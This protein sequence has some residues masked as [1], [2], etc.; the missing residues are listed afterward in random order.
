MNDRLSRRRRA[1]KRARPMLLIAIIVLFLSGCTGLP[2]AKDDATPVRPVTDGASVAGDPK[3]ATATSAVKDKAATPLTGLPTATAR[4]ADPVVTIALGDTITVNG[5]GA[6]V[7]GSAV[8][9]TAGG[10]YSISGKLRNGQIVVDAKDG[11]AVRLVLNGVDI[12]CASSAPI[13]VK[14]AK[15][16]IIALADGTTNHVTDENTGRVGGPQANEP[17]AAIFSKGNLSFEGNGSLTVDAN[18]RNAI[19]SKDDLSITGGDFTVNAVNDGIE[20]RD[21]I[22]IKNG[23]I[24]V[25]A[26]ADGMRSNNDVDPGKGSITI[27]GG[28]VNVTAGED[29]IQAETSVAISGGTIA[30]SS[31]G[32]SANS[33]HKIGSGGNA[34]EN[35]ATASASSVSAKGIK[36]GLNVTIQGGAITVDSSDDA[37]NSNDTL[38]IHDGNLVL[39]SGDDGIHS[40]ITLI[41]DGGDIRVTRSYEAIEGAVIVV[42]G[43]NVHLAASDDGVNAADHRDHASANGRPGR[44]SSGHSVDTHLSVTGGY[45]VVDATGDG[46]D[47]NGWARMTG[48]T[49]IVNGPVVS[50]NGALDYNREFTMAGGTLVAVGSFG[51]AQAPDATS[52]QNSL[53]VSLASPQPA[54]TLVHIEAEDGTGILTF[55]PIRPYQSVVYS[56]SSLKKGSTY[57]VY[58]GG[59]STGSVVDGVYSGGSYTPGVRTARPRI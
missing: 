41:I 31:G 53:V 47:I 2:I 43:G 44:G 11:K 5:P 13:Y 21:H 51:M 15:S 27:E 28:T 54:G 55:A 17:D 45:V 58:I 50:D 26:K 10:T 8:R 1:P 12:T 37:I 19:T 33:R 20:G 24:T 9:I 49:V 29:G 7:D 40:D 57:N 22:A 42:N 48:G 30:V 35:P 36:A 46:L 32:G 23:S 59:R 39:A 52:T 3:A 34:Q 18:Y 56:S 4:S 6:S 25:K 16:T 38:A 14:R